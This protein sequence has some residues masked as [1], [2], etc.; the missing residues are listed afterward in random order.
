MPSANKPT[1]AHN[2]RIFL[3]IAL[4]KIDS[5]KTDWGSMMRLMMAFMIKSFELYKVLLTACVYGI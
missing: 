4:I 1:S 2:H 3:C 5:Y